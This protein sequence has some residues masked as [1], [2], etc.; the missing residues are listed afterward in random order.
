MNSGDEDYSSLLASCFLAPVKSA[1]KR[2][3][4]PKNAVVMAMD[5]HSVHQNCG[6]DSDAGM[7]IS[8]LRGDFLWV[9]DSKKAMES[10]QSPSGING[11]TS[12][13]G[14]RGPMMIRAKSGEYLL[15]PD[16]V[17]LESGENQPNFRVMSTQRL[18]VHGVRVVGC[19]KGQR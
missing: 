8:T 10:I 13:V 9:D 2:D 17:F 1:I 19:F 4:V 14:G 5:L 12:V 15:D 16:A 18:K 11:G 3:F 7:S 6:I